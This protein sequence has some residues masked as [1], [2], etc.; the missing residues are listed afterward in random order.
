MSDPDFN[1]LVALDFLLA[2]AS[3][4]GAARRLNLSTSAMSRT[5]S[6]LREVTGD[7]ILVRAGRNMVLTPWAEATRDRARNAV[8]EARAVLQP[9]SGTLRVENLERLFTIRAND[10]F[11]VAF[12]PLLI[13]AVAEA[14]PG[15]CIRFAPKPEKTSRYLREGL[16]DLEIG[17]QSNMGPEIRVQRLFQDRFTGA[18]R[19]EHPLASLPEISVEDYIAWGHVVASPDGALHGFVDDALAASGA[20]RKVVSVVPG[21]PTAL[22]VALAS[23]LIAM[24]PALYLRNQRMTENL[25]VFEL[26]FKTRNIVVSQMWH[27]RMEKDPAH[28]WLRE[29]ILEVCRIG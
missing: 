13:A 5:L 26:P 9:S 18:V 2:E 23:D 24:V 25:H 27:P 8:N 11:V 3:V 28:R 21:F 17:V 19:K 4:A 12:G 6:R 15:I 16:V 1:L 29:K 10:G 22:S 20:T 7:P 14:A